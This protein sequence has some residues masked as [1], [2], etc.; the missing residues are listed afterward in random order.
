MR[1]VHKHPNGA[2]FAP[3]L[4]L[5]LLLL[6]RRATRRGGILCVFVVAVVASVVLTHARAPTLALVS[7]LGTLR[8]SVARLYLSLVH[9]NTLLIG[10]VAIDD[11]IDDVC[12][13]SDAV[14]NQHILVVDLVHKKNSSSENTRAEDMVARTHP[15]T[16][17]PY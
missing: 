3:R 14:R 12:T 7:L 10:T 4:L 11:A 8:C 17:S 6:L 9:N 1:V 15:E 2:D 16:C 13:C 5:L